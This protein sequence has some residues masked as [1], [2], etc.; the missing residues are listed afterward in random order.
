[1]SCGDAAIP[2]HENA[3]LVTSVEAEKAFVQLRLRSRA[4]FSY[5]I[6]AWDQPVRPK[7]P[8][9]LPRES[10]GSLV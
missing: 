3:N 5:L 1:M 8:A 9:K 10:Q 6:I 4:E 2:C 7:M